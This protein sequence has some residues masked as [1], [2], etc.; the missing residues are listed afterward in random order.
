MDRAAKFLASEV[1]AVWIM[2]FLF[3]RQTNSPFDQKQNF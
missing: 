3:S 2:S 1:V